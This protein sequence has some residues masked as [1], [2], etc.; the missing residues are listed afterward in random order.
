MI[1]EL[2]EQEDW[3]RY[4]I[5]GQVTT[6]DVGTKALAAERFGQLVERMNFVRFRAA[7]AKASAVDPKV[8]KKLVLVLCM[9]A[10]VERASH[11]RPLKTETEPQSATRALLSSARAAAGPEERSSKDGAALETYGLQGGD[12]YVPMRGRRGCDLGV[13]EG[14]PRLRDFSL[15]ASRAQTLGGGFAKQVW[16]WRR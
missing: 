9:A 7:A 16:L 4:H 2:L 11:G 8:A 13:L 6:A 1:R 5:D 10:L 14:L 3:Q 12:Y 15:Q